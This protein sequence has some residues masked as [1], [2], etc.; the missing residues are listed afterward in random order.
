[1]V[2]SAE[3]RVSKPR[4]QPANRPWAARL[5]PIL[6]PI[7]LP[8]LL[9][10]CG[11][12]G[13]SG[14]G[15]ASSVCT[16]DENKAWIGTYMNDWYF[17]YRTSPRPDPAPY[18]D[19]QS[20]FDALLYTGGSADFPQADRFSGSQ[21]T[22]SFNRLFGDGAT[23]GYG[24]SVAG[25]ELARD[26]SRPLYVRY[27]EPLSPAATAG[28]QRGDR[29]I[30]VNGRSAAE[31]I[32]ADDFAA[33]TAQLTGES[34]ALVLRRA[35]V[36]REVN[37][38]S[39][40]FNLTPVTGTT[41]VTTAGGRR[42]GYVSVKD[43]I[44]QS[45]APL[46]T[47]FARFKAE[48]VQDVVL[49]LRYNGG[50]LV[51]TGATLASYVAGL[52]GNGLNYATLLYND[53]RAAVYNENFRFNTLGSALSLPRVFVLMGRRT[54]SASEQL[55]NGL[56]GA[57][58]EVVAIGETTCGKPVGFLPT[59]ACGRTYSVVNFESV[60]QRNEGRYFDGL[61]PVCAVAEDFT[62]AQASV[63]DPLMNAAKEAADT[64]FCPAVGTGQAFPLAVRAGRWGADGSRR[65]LAE[66]D[67]SPGM[68]AR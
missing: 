39:A 68:L 21:T 60:N 35:G 41:V 45:L 22:E 47:A 67:G 30:T 16:V 25:L 18:T 6:S 44:S 11:G 62:A 27:V 53:K 51:S 54:C 58:V 40:V 20:Y 3:Q 19:A 13:D 56:R 14:G 57:N 10:A 49:D 52:R 43:M 48:R 24:L 64:G 63:A 17:W 33:L 29:V 61:A 15:G 8:L 9:V 55:I 42:L 50:G 46:E 59:N 32:A 38:R 2:Q 7:L 36:D 34:L 37:L 28:V 65:N 12:S 4:A 23:L 66:G 5:S 31:L 26:G 1:V